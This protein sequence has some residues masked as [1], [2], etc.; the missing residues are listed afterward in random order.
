MY[1]FKEKQR[2]DQRRAKTVMKQARN[3]GKIENRRALSDKCGVYD[4]GNTAE[5][6]EQ[7]RE[8]QNVVIFLADQDAECQNK[9]CHTAVAVG[10]D[11]LPANLTV[12]EDLGEP[13]RNDR[14]E[15]QRG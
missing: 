6:T 7:P 15:K 1:P 9:T 11:L 4:C 12:S 2:Y 10:Y 5:N 8:M 14:D 3:C 13:V